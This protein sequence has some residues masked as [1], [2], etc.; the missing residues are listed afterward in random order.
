MDLD[1]DWLRLMMRVVMA[2]IVAMAAVRAVHMGRGRCRR[3]M[4]VGVSALVRV[5]MA[6]GAVGT[7]FGLEGFADFVDDQMHG[8]QHV[9]QHMVGFYLQV[10]GLEFDGYMPVAE[11][12]GRAGQVER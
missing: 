5:A 3:C 1:G 8:P 9:G 7:A 2:V 6:T 10:V 4:W 11:V 12:V